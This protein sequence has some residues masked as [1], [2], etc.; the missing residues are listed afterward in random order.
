MRTKPTAITEL[1]PSPDDERRSRMVRYSIAMGIRLVCIALVVVLPD[2]WKIVPAIGALAL[3]YFAV[4]IAN[5]VRR[6]GG[7]TVARPGALA[8]RT[9][10]KDAA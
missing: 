10:E 6:T 7:S 2:F 1:P 4:V 5:N 3:P 9:P 8:R